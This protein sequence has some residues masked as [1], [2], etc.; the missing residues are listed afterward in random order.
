[1]TKEEDFVMGRDKEDLIKDSQDDLKKDPKENQKKNL[2]Y[3]KEERKERWGFI[4]LLF[5]TAMLVISPI[6]MHIPLFSNFLSDFLSTLETQEYKGVYL[7]AISTLIGTFLAIYGALWTQR[8]IDSRDEVK[9]KRAALVVVYYDFKFAYED[10]KD[11][12]YGKSDSN[13]FYKSQITQETIIKN[14]V[15]QKTENLFVDED[16]IKNVASLSDVFG[17]KV[18][19]MIFQMYG[20][21]NTIKMILD[22]IFKQDNK[23]KQSNG[24]YKIERLNEIL[25]KIFLE[26]FLEEDL[27]EDGIEV[28][29]RN[30]YRKT[31]SIIQSKMKESYAQSRKLFIP[32]DIDDDIEDEK[33]NSENPRQ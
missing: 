24:D 12:I 25:D 31:F 15:K 10:L 23:E 9:K 33:I 30:N 20:E 5:I 27:E 8:R 16:W 13:K 18:L 19:K 3:L 14:I 28:A 2:P 29:L 22:D 6:L 26:E 7:E 17:E 21:I 1:M 11:M 4:F 32:V